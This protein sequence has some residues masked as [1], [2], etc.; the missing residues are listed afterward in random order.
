MSV[1]LFKNFVSSLNPD[2]VILV[3]DG[4]IVR[5]CPQLQLTELPDTI[6]DLNGHALLPG[7]ID[8]HTHFLHS[9]LSLS[10]AQLFSC[11][12]CSEMIDVFLSFDS[13]GLWKKGYGY[14]DS[15]WPQPLDKSGL[16]AVSEVLPVA[17]FR[18]DSHSAV[19]NSAALKLLK[20]PKE[21]DCE[22]VRMGIFSAAAYL[23]LCKHLNAFTTDG[24]REIAFAGACRFAVSKGITAVHALEGGEG[25]GMGDVDFLLAKIRTPY[26]GP[27]IIIYPQTVNLGWIKSRGLSR[28]GGCLLLDGSLGT[29]TAA[30]SAPYNDNPANSGSLYFSDRALLSFVERAHRSGLQ[31]AFH[32]IGDRAI[33]QIV[34]VYDKVLFKDPKRDHRHRIE[35]CELPS[36]AD[37]D[38]ISQ[39]GLYVGV[40]PV[41]DLLW[42]GK[43]SMYEKR[44]GSERAKMANPFRQM[45]RRSIVMGGGS[46]FDVTPMDPLAGIYAAVNHSNPASSLTVEEA[47]ALF[48]S[49]ASRFSFDEHRFGSIAV[50]KKADFVV[51]SHHPYKVSSQNL[52][53]IKILATYA[54]GEKVFSL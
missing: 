18:I 17:A 36:P 21:L 46:D 20:I 3:A 6:I 43:N 48:T 13:P 1:K 29:G 41:F 14:D 51:L 5:I 15:S 25:W 37:I 7:F 16:D 53:E 39:L 26:A 54:A 4:I 45:Y 28:V 2:T 31:T 12:S 8:T 34:S 9:A 23:W 24:E 49:S 27:E 47:V 40:Q 32:A 42:N 30:L 35:H 19:I 10:S 44:L 33:K 22:K 11:R 52:R 50:R 38:K